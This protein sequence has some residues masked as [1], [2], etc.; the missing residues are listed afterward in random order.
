MSDT[1]DNDDIE[2]IGEAAR[3]GRPIREARAY[4]VAIA[5]DGLDFRPARIDDPVPLGRQ[6][7]AAAN[8]TPVGEYSLFLILP[9]GD[10]EDVRLDEP[11]DLRAKGAE[12]FVAFRSDREFSLTLNGKQI[13]W[14]RTTISGTELYTLADVPE[15]EAVYLDVRGGEDRLVEPRDQLDLTA[16]GIER[17]ITAP[18]PAFAYEIIVNA[19]PRVVTG[20]PVTFEQIVQLAFPGQHDPNVVFSMTYRHAFSKPHAG[21]LSPGKTIEVKKGT[22]FNVT[23][24]VQS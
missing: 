14:G 2:D 18:R 8:L 13:R 12:K 16:S 21:E 24:T 10:F 4:R 6:L 23:R 11:M 1:T 22:V 7:L 9:S 17:F 20:R 3:E 15:D 19:R 5:V